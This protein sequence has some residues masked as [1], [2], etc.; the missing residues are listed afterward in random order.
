MGK[1]TSR[2][3]GAMVSWLG[4]DHL[5]PVLRPQSPG[6]T[7]PRPVARR[8]QRSRADGAAGFLLSHQ[9]N[10]GVIAT[11]RLLAKKHAV[12]WLTAPLDANGKTFPAGTI[13]T[14]SKGS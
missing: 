2:A 14:K 1:E 13:S 7:G 4:E 12:Y 5:A 11:N 10:D 9:V 6:P 8:L 3:S